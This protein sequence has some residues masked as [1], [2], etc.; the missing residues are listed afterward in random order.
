MDVGH[1]LASLINYAKSV[2]GAKSEMRKMSEELFALK[3]V[4]EHLASQSSE[5]TK[6]PQS[7]GSESSG[8]FNRDIMARV[9]STTKEFLQTLL[10][11]LETPA[12]KFKRLKQKLEWPF[13]QDQ[14]NTHLTKLERVKSWL[15]LVLM[16]DHASGDRDLQREMSTL[17]SSLKEDLRIRNQER[18]QMANKELFKW[19]APASP[20][21]SH[22]R[23]SKA[24]RIGTGKWFIDGHLKRWL[25]DWKD[26]SRIL[27]LVGKCKSIR[28]LFGAWTDTLSSW[29]WK[30]DPF[31]CLF[32]SY[33]P[34]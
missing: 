14:V 26:Q 4:L 11:D 27:F 1:I 18:S 13:T 3:G 5:D 24:K 12:T 29:D 10:A 16:A 33:L 34:T 30:D 19:I 15:I 9:L 21:N 17:T 7:G 2:Q 6:Q 23:A 32:Y 31:V 20:A 8:Q 28:Q 25:R 22:L